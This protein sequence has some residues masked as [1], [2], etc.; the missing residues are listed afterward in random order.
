MNNPYQI[1]SGVTKLS[2]KLIGAAVLAL[3]LNDLGPALDSPLVLFI[4]SI[5]FLFLLVLPIL[6]FVD[7]LDILKEMRRRQTSKNRSSK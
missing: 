1:R 3:L 7:V 2:V 5:L 6:C 4:G